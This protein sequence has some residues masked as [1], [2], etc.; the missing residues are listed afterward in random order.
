MKLQLLC[1]LA[2]VASAAVSV[3]PDSADVYV[4]PVK[5]SDSGDGS[6]A[7]PFQTLAKTQTALRSLEKKTAVVVHLAAGATFTLLAPLN[8]SAADS[9]NVRWVGEGSAGVTVSGGVRL[10]TWT[11]KKATGRV[12]L[13]APP[14]PP[15]PN[16]TCPAFPVSLYNMRC[17]GFSSV[18]HVKTLDECKQACCN[19]GIKQCTAFQLWNH[20]DCKR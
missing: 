19:A 13:T 4:D 5:G 8:F 11:K 15:T 14:P 10:P 9:G 6:A 18:I 12:G 2:L 7:R 1:G 16:A 17:A 3:S 20:E